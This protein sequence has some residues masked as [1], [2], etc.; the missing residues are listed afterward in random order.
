MYQLYPY[1]P[2][3]PHLFVYMCVHKH[4]HAHM[5]VCMYMCVFVLA[6]SWRGKP[7]GREN[8]MHQHA[9]CVRIKLGPERASLFATCR[10]DPVCRTPLLA[11]P[12]D[13]GPL[14]LLYGVVVRTCLG[15]LVL[16]FL[17]WPAT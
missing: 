13:W 8:G 17:N 4:V 2:W 9:L 11:P 10:L 6:A 14:L 3:E 7:P 12:H 15:C 5:H 1:G 16:L